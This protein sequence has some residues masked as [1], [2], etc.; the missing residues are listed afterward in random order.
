MFIE[1]LVRRGVDSIIESVP[2][3]TGGKAVSDRIYFGLVG[4]ESLIKHRFFQRKTSPKELRG[5]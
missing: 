3:L 2:I 4:N 1:D 5:I